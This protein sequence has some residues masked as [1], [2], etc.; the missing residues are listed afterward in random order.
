MGS[1]ACHTGP[2]MPANGPQPA[3]AASPMPQSTCAA[4]G[5]G[6]ASAARR[7]RRV[8]AGPDSA[9]TPRLYARPRD[10]KSEAAAG[11]FRT[12]DLDVVNMG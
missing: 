12:F 10:D 3:A 1:D 8:A 6:A 11:G 7:A 4:L 2:G 5:A 9:G